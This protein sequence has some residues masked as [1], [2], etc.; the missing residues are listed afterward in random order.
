MKRKPESK[1]GK[2]FSLLKKKIV[3]VFERKKNVAKLYF[4]SFLFFT[5]WK[6][7]AQKKNP[8]KEY[9]K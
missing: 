4:I 6:K 7:V 3:I 9:L 8:I 2:F 5:F 1:C